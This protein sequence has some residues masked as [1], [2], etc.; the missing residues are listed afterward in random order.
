MVLE[1]YIQIM[2][3]E[4]FNKQIAKVKKKERKKKHLGD[5]LI[6]MGY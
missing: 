5:L 1:F 3:V 2:H 6:I 4:S